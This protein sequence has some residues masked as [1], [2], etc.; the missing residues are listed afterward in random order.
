MELDPSRPTQHVLLW[1]TNLGPNNQ[2]QIDDVTFRRT[3]P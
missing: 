2:T 3:A 1:I